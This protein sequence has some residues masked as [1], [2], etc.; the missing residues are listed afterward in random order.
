MGEV[1][2]AVFVRWGADGDEDQLGMGDRVTGLG[3]EQQAAFL[4]VL[5]EHAREAGFADGRYALAQ[6]IDLV[7][8]DID[9]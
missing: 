3:A 8:I 6:L 5:F 2:R 4:D 1:S 9:G 7:G